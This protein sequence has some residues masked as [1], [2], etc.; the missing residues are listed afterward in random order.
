MI[1]A[2]F[3]RVALL[4][5][6]LQCSALFSVIL[7]AIVD[8]FRDAAFAAAAVVQDALRRGT[9]SAHRACAITYAPALGNAG[10]AAASKQQTSRLIVARS[11]K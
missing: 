2:D 8:A 11:A 4:R 9:G 6:K 10:P 3:G 1:A 5:P 7:I